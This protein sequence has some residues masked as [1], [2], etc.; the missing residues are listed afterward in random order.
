MMLN[1]LG[2]WQIIGL[3]NILSSLC[4]TGIIVTFTSYSF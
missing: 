1:P 2:I 3:A 4:A